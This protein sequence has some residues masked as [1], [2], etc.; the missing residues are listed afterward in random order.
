MSTKEINLRLCKFPKDFS[1]II[2]LEKQCF[3]AEAFPAFEF[4]TLYALGRETFWVV[5]REKQIIGYISAYIEEDYGYIASIAVSPDARREGIGAAM[6][7][8]LISFLKSKPNIKGII[9]QV[10]QSNQSAI[11]LYKKYKFVPMTLIPD[12][13][14]DKETAI[15]MQLDF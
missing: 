9:L 1:G 5:E 2:R 11:A 3:G 12:Y 7:E 8:K 14:P 6:I 4:L 15:E 10:R 13:Y